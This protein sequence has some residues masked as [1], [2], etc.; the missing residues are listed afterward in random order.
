MSPPRQLFL[1][2][3]TITGDR[4]WSRRR[5]AASELTSLRQDLIATQRVIEA[6]G[7]HRLLAFDRDPLTG[8]PTVEVAH[9]ALL[10]EWPR[11]RGWIDDAHDDVVRHTALVAA[12]MEWQ[13]AGCSAGYL[14]AGQRLADYEAWI[15]RTTLDLTEQEL[16]FVERSIAVRDDED[17]GDAERTNREMAL[18]KRVRR[19]TVGLLAV[20]LLVT[21]GLIVAWLVIR[22]PEMER[23]AFVR[24]PYAKGGQQQQTDS[25]WD[26]AQLEHDFD[27]VTLTPVSEPTAEIDALADSGFDLI[28]IQQDLINEAYAAAA[29][30][31]DIRFLAF[32]NFGRD[33][34]LP[35]LTIAYSPDVAAGT[36]LAGAAAALTSETGTIGYLGGH[37]LINDPFRAGYEAG[38]RAIDPD[39]EIVSTYLVQ[40]GSLDVFTRPKDGA[41]LAADLYLA[42]ADVV[43]HAAGGSGDLVPKVADEMSDQLGQHLWVIGVDIDQWLKVDAEQREHVLTSLLKRHDLEIEIAVDR[44]FAGELEPGTFA[45]GFA[46]GIYA[47]STSGGHLSA[48]STARLDALSDELTKGAITVSDVPMAAPT[49]LPTADQTIRVEARGNECFV[50]QTQPIATGTLRVEFRNSTEARREGSTHCRGASARAR[51]SMMRG[52]HSVCSPHLV[53]TTRA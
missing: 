30:H 13:I 1:R 8:S 22:S 11:L 10:I 32:D 43:F 53:G 35:N 42:G 44:F 20:V 17:R 50:E 12:M 29:A 48:E 19:R 25:G 38:A 5:V 45:V 49:M 7:A 36:Y 18:A 14:L 37:P 4:D 47:L 28:V 51:I 31:P 39:I 6:F 9:E 15:D 23:I 34:G 26:Q 16:E 41:A 52:R 21:I 27:A 46:D 2:L 33:M 3:V 40:S 24:S